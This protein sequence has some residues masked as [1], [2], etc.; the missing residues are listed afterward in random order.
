MNPRRRRPLFSPAPSA[1]LSELARRDSGWATA[2]GMHLSRRA[3][4]SQAVS[5]G[6]LPDPLPIVHDEDGDAPRVALV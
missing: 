5:I 6:S 1:T 3:A 4:Q 2:T